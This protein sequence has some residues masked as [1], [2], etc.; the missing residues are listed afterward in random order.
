MAVET[1]GDKEKTRS[2]DCLFYG[3]SPNFKPPTEAWN[4]T[5]S[6]PHP[7]SPLNE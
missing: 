1:D 6:D 2:Y 7:W 4:H 3:G 5:R